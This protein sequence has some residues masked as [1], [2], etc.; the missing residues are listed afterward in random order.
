MNASRVRCG[1]LGLDVAGCQQ[2]DDNAI[3]GRHGG[4]VTCCVPLVGIGWKIGGCT[5]CG[6]KVAL[7]RQRPVAKWRWAHSPLD[8]ACAMPRL[9]VADG[10]AGGL[11]VVAVVPVA[12]VAVHAARRGHCACH[13]AD[14]SAGNQTMGMVWRLRGELAME[15][16][17]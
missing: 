9:T 10:C 16:G 13:P 15:P 4:C 11:C 17:H 3:L 5:R 14:E 7:P 6:G 2:I 8:C 1:R 12:S